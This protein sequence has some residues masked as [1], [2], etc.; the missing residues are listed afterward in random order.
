M[1]V[2]I[3]FFCLFICTINGSAQK[4]ISAFS[5]IEKITIDGNLDEK[6]WST[7][8]T[9]EDFVQFKPHPGLA[10]TQRTQVKLMYDKDALY[11]AAIC[12]DSAEHISN[13]LCDRDD[14]NANIDNFQIILDTYNDDQNGFSFGVSSMGVQYD[15]K[16]TATSESVE[17]NM[18]WS[19]AVKRTEN[20]WELE[21]RIPYSAIRFPKKE[22]QN[23]GINFYRQI[24]R[25]R[26]EATWSPIKPD[27][28]NWLVQ[29]GDATGIKGIEPPLRLAFMPYI[30][31]YADHFPTGAANQSEW[32][33]SFNGGMDIKL[34][35]NEAFTLDM[36]L[37]PD[38]GQ[39]VFD[40]QVL[41][42]SPF[43]IQF[44]E[45]RQFF[46]EGTELFNK[47]GLFYSRRIGIQS[48]YEVLSTNLNQNEYLTNTPSS[49]KLYNATKLSGR[50]KSGLGIGV[51]NGITAEQ[52]STAI[53]SIT[54]AERQIVSSPLTNYNVVV[55]D[56][57]LQN[58]SSITLT[59]TN[60]MREG[61]FYDANVTG[62]NTK[63]NSKNNKYF[64][65]GSSSL[66]N[67]FSSQNVSTGYNFGVSSGKQSG[68]FIA[69]G[70]YFEESHTFDPN[71]LGFNSNN[72]KRIFET[73]I[74]Y[75]I[76]KPFWKLNQF[77]SNLNL[78]Y[79]RLYKPN[80]YTA[81]YINW[82]NFILLKKFHAA[83]IRMNGSLTESFDYFEPRKE[84]MFF[85]RPTWLDLGAWFSS[86][87][88]KKFALDFGFSYTFIGREN[89]TEFE[90][91]VSPRFRLS[92]KMFLVYEFV[93]NYSFNGQ[94]YA[95][96]FSEPAIVTDAVVFGS[97]DRFNTTNTI[98]FRYTLTN[99][100][101]AT[102]RLRHYRS[103]IS[104]NSF[105]N[106]NQDGSLTPNSLT[107]MDVNGVSAYNT[108]FNAF[109]IDLVYRWVFLPGSE[110]N[111]VWKNA[112]FSSDELVTA[113]YFNNLTRMFD[114]QPSN[115]FSIKVLYWLDYQSLKRKSAKQD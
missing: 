96:A 103:S 64:V 109:T 106:L 35:L 18:V 31:A 43:E 15:S 4:V 94:G 27:L 76:F 55:L 54:G 115:S 97:R 36:T 22:I 105:F 48:P 1:H 73:S 62:L 28:E 38:F 2:K 74:A 53:N 92:D 51:F 100:M 16:L 110:I 41:N 3:L 101:S 37:V 86:N 19:S 9:I 46:T 71:D 59:N 102:F 32:S 85:T 89:W 88:Q 87:Y 11:V 17:L 29:S 114:Y 72:N 75:R 44:N 7:A 39:V 60:V 108:N 45:N 107:G 93:Q 70:S 42:V 80:V 113:S 112:I 30:S 49:S 79:N 25:N 99:R 91:N 50:T 40:N 58:N 61:L 20:G 95:V 24:C 57:N 111:I 23:W 90:Y 66:S 10:S 13:V 8:Q 69:S 21:M 63:I 52:Y 83:G 84:G 56:Q 12:Y 34:G 47:S 82:N 104:Y 81:T 33:G 78:S 98:N 67:K 6:D 14:F 26:E 68:N 65:A 5:T 77:S